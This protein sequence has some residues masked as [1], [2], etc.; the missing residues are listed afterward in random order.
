MI[1]QG[2]GGK[3]GGVMTGGMGGKMQAQAQQRR[4]AEASS[5]AQAA[6][7]QDAGATARMAAATGRVLF[8]LSQHLLPQFLAADWSGCWRL[9]CRMVV[10][11]LHRDVAFLSSWLQ[12]DPARDTN[13]CPGIA[14]IMPYPDVFS[15]PQALLERPRPALCPTS[16]Q[17][18]RQTT[19][20]RPL[21]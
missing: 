18:G 14:L 12:W 4:R 11:L 16:L 20:W 1:D 19:I 17:V 6:A 2:D 10:G 21:R 3:I 7:G 9:G 5:T 15:T 8:V 13:S